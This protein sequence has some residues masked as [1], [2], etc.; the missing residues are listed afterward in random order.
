MMCMYVCVCVCV[1]VC[2]FAKQIQRDSYVSKV[3]CIPQYISVQKFVQK[4]RA[5]SKKY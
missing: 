4:I 1:C 3:P 2:V 5:I